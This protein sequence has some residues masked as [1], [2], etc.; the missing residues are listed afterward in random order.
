VAS[1]ASEAAL[2]VVSLVVVVLAVELVPLPQPARR[3]R[4]MQRASKAANNFF[5]IRNTPFRVIVFG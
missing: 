1:W 2:E 4:T 5:F 3:P